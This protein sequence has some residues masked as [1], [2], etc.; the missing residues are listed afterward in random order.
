VRVPE[1]SESAIKAAY[2]TRS[3][4]FAASASSIRAV[5]T[6]VE[7]IVLVVDVVAWL[8]SRA[9]HASS[10]VPS[11]QVPGEVDESDVVDKH[12]RSKRIHRQSVSASHLQM[13]KRG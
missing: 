9:A 3:C 11:I 6:C 2:S 7:R 13:K 10:R 5:W 12:V 1:L 8:S 4:P